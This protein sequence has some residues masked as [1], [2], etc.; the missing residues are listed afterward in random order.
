MTT[1]NVFITMYQ[2]YFDENNVI[3]EENSKIKGNYET[4]D[5]KS[6]ITMKKLYM[7]Q[8]IVFYLFFIYYILFFGFLVYHIYYFQ[9]TDWKMTIL[10]IL[11][12]CFLPQIFE[13][14]SIAISYYISKF[15]YNAD[16][17]LY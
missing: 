14:F 6:M 10:K 11:F 15:F 1:Q 16:G 5:A 4:K 8:N 7:T 2:K 17:V 12:F 3:L 9:K 13:V